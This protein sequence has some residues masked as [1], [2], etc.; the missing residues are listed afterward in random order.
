MWMRVRKLRIDSRDAETRRL[1]CGLA[2]QRRLADARFVAENQGLALTRADPRQ[3]SI[4]HIALG[5]SAH[6]AQP[7]VAT[8]GERWSVFPASTTLTRG[9]RFL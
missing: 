2:Q 5:D 4:E 1:S 9:Q 8:M 7:R 3:N 6:K